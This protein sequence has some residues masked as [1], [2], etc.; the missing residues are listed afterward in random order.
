M[1]S[2]IIYSWGG[3]GGGGEGGERG[4]GGV[5][6]GWEGRLRANKLTMVDFEMFRH[7]PQ[8]TLRPGSQANALGN[9]ITLRQAI[10]SEKSRT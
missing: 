3:G 1:F 2:Y 4:E 10:F 5:V 9:H 6:N 7:R 8:S